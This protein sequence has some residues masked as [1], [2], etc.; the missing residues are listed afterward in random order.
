M[1][2]TR[3]PPA[4]AAPPW[5]GVLLSPL[6]T[7]EHARPLLSSLPTCRCSVEDGQIRLTHS[8]TRLKR[9]HAPQRLRMRSFNRAIARALASTRLTPN[10]TA[11]IQFH[12]TTGIKAWHSTDLAKTGGTIHPGALFI[13]RMSSIYCGPVTCA[14]L[15]AASGGQHQT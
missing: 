11:T 9:H 4:S 1:G 2:L 10:I 12:P 7:A 8:A 5:F 15:A 13:Q 3:F 6:A 14:L